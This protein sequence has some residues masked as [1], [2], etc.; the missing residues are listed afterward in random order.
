MQEQAVGFA[1]RNKYGRIGGNGCFFSVVV[2]YLVSLNYGTV[3]KVF[4][5]YVS[6]GITIA[7]FFV[8]AYLLGG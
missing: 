8:I 3:F 2:N 6:F 4:D 5:M 1:V 7:I